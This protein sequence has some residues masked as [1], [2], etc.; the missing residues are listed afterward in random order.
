MAISHKMKRNAFVVFFL[1][2]LVWGLIFLIGDAKKNFKEL[3][4]FVWWWFPV[5]LVFV[6]VNFS[7]REVKWN[8]FR[9]RAGVDVPRLPSALIYF[10][11]YS[12]CIS[13]GRIG[14]LIKP[15]MYKEYYDQPLKRT[16]PL[17][18]CERLTD[19]LGMLVL[20]GATLFAF[21]DGIKQAGVDESQA[22][23][24]LGIETVAPFLILSVVL[25][26]VLIALVRSRR[27]VGLMLNLIPK[28]EKLD[29]IKEKLEGL[30]NSTYPLLTGYN[31]TAM[32]LFATFSWFFECYATYVLSRYGLGVESI[33][34]VQVIFIFC[35]ASI[36]GGLFFLPGGLGG[37]EAVMIASYILLGAADPAVAIT[38][39]CRAGT[40]FFGVAVG[41]T[42]IL[43]TTRYFHKAVAW[44]EFEHM[45]E[46]AEAENE[47]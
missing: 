6:F 41:V 22:S 35:F 10:S 39:L 32:T 8:F 28:H 26:A 40:L 30:Y 25:L 2:L 24:P 21:I 9:K 4:E 38:F 29:K 1:F 11:G 17:V 42:A 34:L 12:M 16:I 15:L 46:D 5:S 7:L 3:S 31:L 18:F 45:A 37:F 19:L 44:D 27:F 36:V 33:T 43:I 23:V 47:A 14:E 13:P 20:C